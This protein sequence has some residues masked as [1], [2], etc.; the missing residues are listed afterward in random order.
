MTDYNRDYENR[1]GWFVGIIVTLALL[2]IGFWVFSASQR[3]VHPKD[4]IP[5]TVRYVDGYVTRK[6]SPSPGVM[7]YTYNGYLSCLKE[8]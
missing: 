6:F 2:A 1:V 5:S 8:G 3:T 7:C 4:I